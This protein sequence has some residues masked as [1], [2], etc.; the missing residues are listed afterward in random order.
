MK[1]GNGNKNLVLSVSSSI[2]VFNGADGG[3]AVWVRTAMLQTQLG[4]RHSLQGG[5]MG[6]ALVI[7]WVVVVSS[8]I[9]HYNFLYVL[10]KRKLNQTTYN[11]S[12]V[13]WWNIAIQKQNMF[14]IYKEP[15]FT[16]PRWSKIQNLFQT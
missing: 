3:D 10:P 2:I 16:Y 1:N 11:I 9:S 7:E 14:I 6:H 13:S 4:A 8:N 12:K 15:G 5:P